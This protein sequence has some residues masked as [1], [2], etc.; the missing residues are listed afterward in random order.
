MI[1]AVF[2]RLIFLLWGKTMSDF[3]WRASA[4]LALALML[5][6]CVNVW[7]TGS[8]QGVSSSLVDFLYPKGQ[9][10]PAQD[11]S[12]PHLTLPLRVGL[13]FVP[14]NARNVEGLSEAHK[15]EL[16]E[17]VKKSFAGKEYIREISIIPDTYLRSGKGFDSLDQVGRLYGVDVM[18]LVSYDQVSHLEDN[19]A[20]LLYWTIVGAY[21]IKGSQ[22]EVQTFV[23]TAVFDLRS[24]KLL[25]RAPGINRI[26]K[27]ST[28]VN[29]AED[30]RKSREQSFN[31]AIN[32]MIGNLDQELASFRERIK[33]D[34]SVK[35]SYSRGYSGG[36]GAI[37]PW[38]LAIAALALVGRRF[39][40]RSR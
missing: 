34:Q 31:L 23:D 24:H 32:D 37:D 27:S 1:G 40:N 39:L 11:E 6:G 15:A 30:L 16:L 18:A 5:A 38:W 35:I 10:P 12:V 13:A 22:N 33:Q 9:I 20:S 3:R 29:S 8:R 36:G 26:E 19:K 4:L 17:T 14:S 7:N 21:V 28:L 2:T 25:L